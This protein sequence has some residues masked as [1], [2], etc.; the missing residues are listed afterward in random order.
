M[1]DGLCGVQLKGESLG[2][3]GVGGLRA[4]GSLSLQVSREDAEARA[5]SG[6]R[7]FLKEFIFL[8]I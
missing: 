6:S 4:W 7:A 3:P 8:F 2:P 1:S 5:I